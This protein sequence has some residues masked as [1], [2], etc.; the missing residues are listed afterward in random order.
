[1]YTAVMRI[2]VRVALLLADPPLAVSERYFPFLPTNIQDSTQ[3]MV[4]GTTGT[5]RAIRS[6]HISSLSQT[7]E[8]PS[9]Q[10]YTSSLVY[11]NLVFCSTRGSTWFSTRYTPYPPTTSNTVRVEISRKGR[12]RVT[13]LVILSTATRNTE[14][15][16]C[17]GGCYESVTKVL[18][19]CYYC[20]I[21][22]LLRC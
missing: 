22:V 17:R 1:M 8:V 9:S 16:A 21:N 5:A 15:L 13:V 19:K 4:M 14:K 7:W 2:I 12:N 6:N 3:L 11:T 20:V 10:Q 18:I